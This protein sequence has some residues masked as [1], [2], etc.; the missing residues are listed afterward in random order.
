MEFSIFG[1][2]FLQRRKDDDDDGAP[3][4]CAVEIARARARSP[5]AGIREELRFAGYGWRFMATHTRACATHDHHPVDLRIVFVDF[6][7]VVVIV[8]GVAAD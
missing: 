4:F 5:V 7:V 1:G 8:V 2:E 3:N 6:V